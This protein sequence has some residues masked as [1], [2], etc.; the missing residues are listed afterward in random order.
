MCHPGTPA[1]T[2]QLAKDVVT[3]L[4]WAAEPEHD[5][6]KQ[7]GIKAVI[8][9]SALTAVALYTKRFKWTVIKSRKICKCPALIARGASRLRVPAPQSTTRPR[10]LA[11][12]TEPAHAAVD[13]CGRYSGLC[14][15][16]FVEPA[17]LAYPWIESAYFEKVASIHEQTIFE[18]SWSIFH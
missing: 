17:V 3:F 6:R 2:S 1:T 11:S 5:V 9:F 16:V 12:S 10:T 13:A 8:L 7:Y 15:V 18:R 4:N 14:A